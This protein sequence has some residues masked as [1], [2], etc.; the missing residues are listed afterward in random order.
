MIDIEAY[1]V[2]SQTFQTMVNLLRY[3]LSGIHVLVGAIQRDEEDFGGNSDSVL[4]RIF[5]QGMA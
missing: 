5:L 4:L 2:H 1:I 3:K